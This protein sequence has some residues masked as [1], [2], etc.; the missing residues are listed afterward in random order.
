M[1]R[2]LDDD[3]WHRASAAAGWCVKDVVAH[4]GSLC[5]E[6]FGPGAMK[7]LRTT[8]IE[9]TN[10]EFVD[11]RRTWTPT[12]TLAEYERWTARGIGLLGL[13]S[14]TPL[15]RMR[16]PLCELGPL[17]RRADSRSAGVRH[18]Y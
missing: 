3:E 16:M 10:D 15:V 9:R 13:V 8:Q 7:I 5:H 2:D 4:M 6:L 17:S 12:Q 18:P 14:R 1:C 11:D